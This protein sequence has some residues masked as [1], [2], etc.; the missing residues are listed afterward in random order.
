LKDRITSPSLNRNNDPEMQEQPIVAELQQRFREQANEL[1]AFAQD[2]RE[3][4]RQEETRFKAFESALIPMVF[5][6]GRTLVMLFLAA[7]EER[8]ARRTP[9]RMRRDGRR[10]RKLEAKGRNLECWF[11]L[12]RYWRTYMGEDAKEDRRGFHPLD[13]ALGLTKDRLSMLQLLTDGDLDLERYG[14]AYFPEAA[15]TLDVIHVVEKLWEAGACIR[16][17]TRRAAMR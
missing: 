5:A 13:L 12:V 3:E 11:G 8:V 1:M 9:E 16:A 4:G 10:F 7:A 15:H 6:L 14:K 17:S 2:P